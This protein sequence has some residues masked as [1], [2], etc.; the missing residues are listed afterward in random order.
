MRST[1]VLLSE[2]ERIALMEPPAGRIRAVLDTDAYNEIDD[3]FAIAYA[4]LSGEKIDLEAI[5]AAPFH[6]ERSTGPEDGMIRSHQEI[7]RVLERMPEPFGGPV[8]EGSRAW[9]GGPR[10]PVTSPAAEDLISRAKDGESPLYVIA[11][12]AITNVAS[13]ILAA[14]EII[15]RVVVVWLGGNPS[16]WRTAEEFNLR[17]DLHASRVLFDSGVPLIHVPCVN[18]AEHLCTTEAEVER[19]VKGRGGL[20]DYLHEVYADVFKDHFARSRVIWDLAPVA[21]LVNHTWVPTALVH[22]PILN[23]NLTW[24]HD[25]ERHLVREAYAVSRDE[26]FGDL[27]R[28]LEAVTRSV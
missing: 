12:G 18:V 5:Y 15:S 26:V 4:L 19:Y 11:I 17:Q 7:G 10:E 16:N 27:F 13:A 22:S 8:L 24:S 3:Q 25:P 23:D 1:D 6:N 21:W 28:K 9:M 20:G 2:A 14:P